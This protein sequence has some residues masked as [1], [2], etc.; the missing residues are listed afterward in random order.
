[1][2]NQPRTAL[3]RTLLALTVLVA[4]GSGI[5]AQDGE[6]GADA[7]DGAGGEP[8][9]K[10][11]AE[12]FDHKFIAQSDNKSRVSIEVP[13]T[14]NRPKQH[15]GGM[16]APDPTIIVYTGQF[17]APERSPGG[18]VW[19]T[20]MHGYANPAL[21]LSMMTELNGWKV[22]DGTRRLGDKFAECCIEETEDPI[23]RWFRFEE[24]AGTVLRVQVAAPK[25][26]REFAAPVAEKI[27][28]SL[29]VTGSFDPPAPGD[30]W[31][32]KKDLGFEVWTNAEDKGVHEL[33][34]KFVVHSR[35]PIE[36]ALKKTLKGKP[37]DTG[38][39]VAW[40][41]DLPADYERDVKAVLGH[42]KEHATLREEDNVLLLD[43][44]SAKFQGYDQT[45]WSVA[46]QQYMRQYFGGTVPYWIRMGLAS[47]GS[48]AGVVEG[49]AERPQATDVSNVAAKIGRAQTLDSY[50][51]KTDKDFANVDDVSKE[52]W[53]WH[54]YFLHGKPSKAQRQAY[55]DSLTILRDT[56][57]VEASYAAWK[58]IDQKAML[59]DL[60][61]WVRDKWK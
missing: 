53:A 22:I 17:G 31:K 43:G 19:V 20:P 48:H 51:R 1:M 28:A 44:M 18:A 46:A 12:P 59:A 49:K 58:D 3:L 13:S 52:L 9:A 15:G 37:R 36:A 39:P 8:G 50:F 33:A 57:D 2:K 54:Y 55:V 47:Y 7:E 26:A 5:R 56:G 14:W 25:L 6:D 23:V 10:I 16:G 32:K 11:L 35:E 30:G 27:L 42:V 40:V 24:H 61:S 21:A 4:F 45:A 41:Y 34:L 38:T 29:K 60:I